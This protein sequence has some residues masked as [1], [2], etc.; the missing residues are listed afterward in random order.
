MRKLKDEN[1]SSV[2]RATFINA[3]R[4]VPSSVTVVTTDG[5]AG[6]HGATVSAFSSVSADPPTILVC[7]RAESRIAQ[8]VTENGQ[9]CVNV[10]S[11]ASQDIARR[12]AG[13]DD[14]MVSDRFSGID[15]HGCSGTSPQID[16]ATIFSARVDQAVS[17]GSHRIFICRVVFAQISSA[18]PLAYLDGAYHSVIPQGALSATGTCL[19]AA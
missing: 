9:L 8:L 3:M 1:L 14:Q 12:F 10:L 2:P 19:R 13:Q 11:N 6:R 17:T 7:L 5:P 16:G 15:W 18:P 4:M